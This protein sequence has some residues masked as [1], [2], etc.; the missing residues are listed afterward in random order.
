MVF[1]SLFLPRVSSV[2]FPHN[3]L[4]ENTLIHWGWAGPVLI[5]MTVVLFILVFLATFERG[6]AWLLAFVGVAAVALAIYAGTGTRS[7]VE[8]VSNGVDDYAGVRSDLAHGNPSFGIY[9]LGVGGL[10]A[11]IGA[12]LLGRSRSA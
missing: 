6:W 2:S 8:Y 12:L 10:T 11:A 5:A 3:D 1:A 7:N 4:P 9:L